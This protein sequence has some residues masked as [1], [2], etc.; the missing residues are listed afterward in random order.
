MLL[1]SFIGLSWLKFISI[2]ILLLKASLSFKYVKYKVFVL[3][4]SVVLPF[5][6]PAFLNSTLPL[7]YVL[8]VL[9]SKDTF[10]SLGNEDKTIS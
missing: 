1:A 4:C 10:K 6:V 8:N 7:F 3:V 9:L 2:F 5:I